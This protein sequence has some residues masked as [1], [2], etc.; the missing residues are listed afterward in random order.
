MK[1]ENSKKISID[2]SELKIVIILPYFNEIIGLEL[3]E[4]AKE[5]LLRNNVRPENIELIRV[6]G[7]LEIPFACQKIAEILKP[8]AIIAL[9]AIIRGETSHYDMVTAITYKGIMD[10]QLKTNTPIIF[11]VLT[12][13]NTEQA[14]KRSSKEGLNKGLQSA[15]AALIQATL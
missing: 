8:D 13:E 7:A 15:R 2:G 9:G 3:F 14:K 10:T 5:E 12:C 1:L 4:N 6:D 11:G